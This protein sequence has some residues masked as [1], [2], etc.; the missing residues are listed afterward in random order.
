MQNPSGLRIG[1]HVGRPMEE[2]RGGF[3]VLDRK[4]PPFVQKEHKGWGTL[5][6]FCTRY[7]GGER[8]GDEF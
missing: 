5:K 7:N 6:Y 3:V 2:K 1:Q 4:S 8:S